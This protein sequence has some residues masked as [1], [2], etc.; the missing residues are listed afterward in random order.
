MIDKWLYNFFAALDN[1]C[2][3]MD[4]LFK[5]M[6][7]LKMNYYFTGALILAFVLLAFFLQPGYIP[8]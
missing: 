7:S 5:F 4:N 2:L 1:L 8:R 6:M 3:M